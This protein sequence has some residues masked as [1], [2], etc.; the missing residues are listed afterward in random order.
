MTKDNPNYS[1]WKVKIIMAFSNLLGVRIA[2]HHT[3]TK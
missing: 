1:P 3:S 2:L